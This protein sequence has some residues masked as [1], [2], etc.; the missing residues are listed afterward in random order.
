F[1]PSAVNSA[2][3]AA[4]AAFAANKGKYPAAPSSFSPTGGLIY[5]ASGHRSNYSTQTMYVSP[6]VG[7]AYAPE[8]MHEKT[9]FRAGVGLFYNPFNDYSTPQSYGYNVANSFIASNNNML[10]PA[11]TLSDPFPA[12][13]NPIQQP[14]GSS[15]GIN[16]YLGQTILFTN[17][18]P[19]AAY[20][21]RWSFDIQHDLGHNFLVQIGYIGNHQVHM[22]YS[23]PLN[24]FPVSLLSHSPYYDATVSNTYNASVANPFYGLISGSSIGT[25]NKISLSNLYYRYPQY[26]STSAEQ[27]T[28][29]A[30]SNM[31]MLVARLT[32]RFSSGLTANVNYEYS[33]LLSAANPLNPGDALWYGTGASDFPQHLAVTATYDLPFGNGRWIGKDVNRLTDELIG[34]W[35][36]AG[37]YM[38][39][40]GTALNWGN[41]IYTGNWH[42]FNNAAHNYQH[43]FNTSV[44]DTRTKDANGNVV[45]PNAFN[46]RTFPMYALR[47]DPSNNLDCSLL[48]NVS[49]TES[50]KL[51]LRFEAYNALNHPQFSSPNVSPTSSSFGVSTGQANTPRVLQLGARY[52]F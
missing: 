23:A 11:T 18:N 17:P 21:I 51:Q 22:S 50:T 38:W 5:A 2:T 41:V 7:V 48:K 36:L 14:Y 39:E 12:S 33:R 35:Q 49:V 16:T 34:G 20:S 28:P 47:S 40:S 45:Q 15:Q 9:V 4:E 19:K 42:D 3:T 26:S 10:T 25:S 24:Y 30:W 29:V 13:L 32:K 44:F 31:N 1:D 6:R 52:V 8:S 27:L 43:A 37:V 46:Y